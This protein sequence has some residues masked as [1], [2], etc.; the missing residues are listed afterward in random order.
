MTVNH[1]TVFAHPDGTLSTYVKHLT[2]VAY[3]VAAGHISKVKDEL[4]ND[5]SLLNRHDY[6][7]NTLLHI[8]ATG[9]DVNI[10]KYLGD[11]SQWNR[12]AE[13]NQIV[14]P[15]FI[16]TGIVSLKIPPRGSGNGG[17]VSY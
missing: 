14:P 1:A 3:A 15:D 4:H 9:P 17:I 12:I 13:L 7:G 11:A 10:L 8:A 16:L 5:I 6:S 2:E